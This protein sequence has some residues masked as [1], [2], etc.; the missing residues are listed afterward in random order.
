MDGN[1]F[2]S[3]GK[4]IAYIEHESDA[5]VYLWSGHVAAHF[6]GELIYGWNGYQ[7]GWFVEG[8]VYDL[9]GLRVGSLG[10]KCPRALQPL[11]L[12]A[13]Q[14]TRPPRH[15][16]KAEH[17]RPDFRP[18]YGEQDFEGFWKN[19]LANSEGK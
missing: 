9:N 12:K 18:G 11:P 3:K 10:D 1:L 2:D 14:R 19:G 7:L 17:K 16:H 13:A 5:M 8:V 4:A 6:A 15:E